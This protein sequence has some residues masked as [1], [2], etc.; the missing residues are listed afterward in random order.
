M[1]DIA[2][3]GGMDRALTELIN[4]ASDRFEFVVFS[5]T[6][7]DDLRGLVE[8]HRVR[9]VPA[10][11]IP[12]KFALFFGLGGLRLVREKVDLVC[13]VGAVVPNRFDVAFVHYCH[14]GFRWATGAS[15][16]ADGSLPR[17]VNTSILRGLSIAAERWCYRPARIS[18]L[19]AVSRGL[20]SELEQSFS[21]VPV[22]VVPNGVDLE[23]F[24][25]DLEARVQVRSELGLAEDVVVALFVGGDWERKGLACAVDGLSRATRAAAVPLQL[26]VV[27]RGDRDAY[28]AVARPGGVEA[29]LRFLGPRD[30]VERLYQAADVFVLPSLY[31]TFSLVAY[32][33]AA[34]GLPVVGTRVSGVDELAEHG[35]GI[36]VDRTPESVGDALVRLA[37]DG[38]LRHRLGDAGR[39]IARDYTWER[40]VEATVGLFEQVLIEKK[41]H[42]AGT[43]FV[44]APL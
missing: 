2:P 42:S 29:S 22:T 24:S 28:A 4:R 26:W 23:R 27:G 6:L 36:L 43:E 39:R 35:G 25:P 20:A 41:S 19:V 16:P 15:A 40:S 5:R 9:M 17:R 31:E 11:P 34:S 13:A 1:H 3:F 14:T 12:I 33:A 30:D 37:S 7:A 38:Q 44:G 21:G 8:W 18:R 32:E 10:R